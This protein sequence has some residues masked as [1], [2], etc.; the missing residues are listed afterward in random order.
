MTER[1]ISIASSSA[2]LSAILHTPA[3]DSA[4]DIADTGVLIIVGGPQYRVGSH[5]QFVKLSRALAAQGVASMRL[6]TA[7]MGDSSGA[8]T[9]F[10]QQDHDINQA[11]AAF[12]QHYPQLKK[13]V[14]WGLCD[15]AS[16]ILIKLNQ[17]DPR[18]SGIIL[19]NPWVRQ[20]HSHAT[21][22]LK[23]YYLKRL[24]S[25][26]FWQKALGGGL[27]LRHSITELLKTIRQRKP[28]QSSASVT[29]LANEHN[30]VQLMLSGWQNFSGKVLLL[31]SGNDLTAQEFLQLCNDDCAWGAC[32]A[33]AQHKHI[34]D[35]NHTFASADWRSQVEQHSYL[36]IKSTL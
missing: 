24:L 36:F 19:L 8:K 3:T 23:H 13:V 25:R 34:A 12:F 18:I 21:V 29:P 9:A 15:A 7:G 33:Q 16:A 6:D 10:Y 1:Y 17:P 20:Q 30:Y 27:A 14:L 35:A 2:T 26:Q 22:M 31:S 4:A 28:K 5:R 32:L 11:I